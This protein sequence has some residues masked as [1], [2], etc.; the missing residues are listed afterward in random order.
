MI[1]PRV[2]QP[3]YQP[4]VA[5]EVEY[6]WLVRSKQAVEIPVTQAVWVLSFRLQLV[7]VNYIDVAYF[8]VGEFISQQSRSSECFLRRYI[9]RTSHHYIWFL[10]L[11]VAGRA[12]DTDASRAMRDCFLHSQILKVILFIADDY[13]DVI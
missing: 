10:T 7:Q 12:P 11:I 13:V 3:M 1:S 4:W 5:M 6:D 9:A 8:Q 2:G